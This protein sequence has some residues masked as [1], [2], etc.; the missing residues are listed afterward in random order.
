MTEEERKPIL[1][2]PPEVDPLL[3][4]AQKLPDWKKGTDGDASQHV[5]DADSDEPVQEVYEDSLDDEFGGG[6]VDPSTLTAD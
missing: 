4:Q 6:T 5:R 2:P 1:P 3:A